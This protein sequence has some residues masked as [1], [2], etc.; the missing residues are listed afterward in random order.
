MVDV[1]ESIDASGLRRWAYRCV[2]SLTARCDEIDALNV[3]PIPD[4]DTGTNLMFTFRAAVESMRSAGPAAGAGAIG[5]ALA[6]G[7]VSGARG[8]SG[9]IVS[10]LL[11]AVGEAA[12]DGPLDTVSIQAMLRRARVLVAGAVSVPA[13]GTMLTVL[14]AAAHEAAAHDANVDLAT[15]VVDIAEATAR[16]LDRTTDQLAPLREAGVVDAGALGLSVIFD[17]LVE[18]V[19]GRT[20]PRRRYRRP[21][22]HERV[23]EVGVSNAPGASDGAATRSQSRPLGYE[24]LYVVPGIDDTRAAALRAALSDL[25]ESVV[26]AGD[27]SG[28]YSAHVHTTDP[29]GAVECGIAA[30]SIRGV[31]ISCFGLAE[32]AVDANVGEHEPEAMSVGR[33]ILALVAGDGAAALY[34]QEGATVVRC[35]E[36][37]DSS[38]LHRAIVGMKHREVLVLPNGALS[39]QELVAVGAA[40]RADGKDVSMLP[41]SA[42]VQGLAAL[43][44]HD[45]ARAAVDDAFAMSDAAAGTRWGSLRIA[46]QRSLTWVGMCEPGDCL[47]LAGQEVVIVAEHPLDAGCR[48]LDQLLATG[49]EMVTVLLGALAPADLGGRLA[50]YVA[51]AHPGVDVVVYPGGQPGDLV[52][53]GVE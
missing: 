27:G 2:D 5:R 16:A 22:D 4:S 14:E 36:P 49:G 31:R 41:C 39:A 6:V 48:L 8:N 23:I 52:Q 44:V 19:T 1:L 18:V 47:G 38:V 17:A 3:F 51:G 42:M 53:F 13:E 25:G 35:D 12:A 11:R 20:P 26:V 29:G 10:Q 28:A 24:V 37:I 32:Y 9:V 40:A 33:D 45:A 15:L 21:Q 50:D 34:V 43:A 7:A 46:E 30:G